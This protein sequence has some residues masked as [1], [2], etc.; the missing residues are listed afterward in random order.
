MLLE[1]GLGTLINI[2]INNPWFFPVSLSNHNALLGAKQDQRHWALNHK[3]RNEGTAHD[4][5]LVG[6]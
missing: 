1:I 6:A 4:L 3:Q 2:V 5:F